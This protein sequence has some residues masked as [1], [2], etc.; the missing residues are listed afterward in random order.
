[1]MKRI[2]IFFSFLLINYICFA[3]IPLWLKQPEKVFPQNEYIRAMG[4]GTSE[5]LAQNSALTGISQFFNTKVEVLTVA[6]K[7]SNAIISEDKQRFD[8]KQ[9]FSQIAKITSTAEFFCV[10]FTEPYYDKKSDKYSVL[11]Y[12]NRSEA[13]KIYKSRITAIMDSIEEYESYSKNEIEPFLILSLLKKEQTLAV[14]AEKYIQSEILL[15][16]SDSEVYKKDLQ[17][18]SHIKPQVDKLKTQMTFS[19]NMI[20]KEPV[21]NPVFSTIAS[22]L[23]KDGFAYSIS[24]A[25][26]QIIVDIDCIEESYEAGQFVRPSVDIAIV[27]NS[28]NGVYTYSKAFPRIGSKTTEQ[29]Y[30]RAVTKI[31]QDLKDNF[32]QE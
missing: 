6:V 15:V 21:Y 17:T 19:I 5:K 2:S 12:I 31:N 4:E 16:P 27:N 11:A 3:D 30:T 28:G 14:L 25:K 20:Q 7:E 8:S 10:Y 24:G 23:E 32:L 22:I 13:L 29:A 26:Y 18:I 9:S 1:M